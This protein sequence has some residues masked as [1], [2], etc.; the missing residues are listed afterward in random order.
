[1]TVCKKFYDETLKGGGYMNDR[2]MLHYFVEHAP[3]AIA[4][5]EDLGIKVD[6]LT[7]TGGMSRSVRTDHH[8]WHQLGHF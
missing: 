3:L 7:I 8:Q 5:L 2:E 1:M 6:D 4:W